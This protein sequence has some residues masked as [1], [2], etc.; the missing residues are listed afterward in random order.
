MLPRRSRNLAEFF[1]SR[2]QIS[3]T[4][5]SFSVDTANERERKVRIRN[6]S[7]TRGLIISRTIVRPS[8]EYST[9]SENYHPLSLY[10]DEAYDM[11]IV[12]EERTRRLFHLSYAGG[13]KRRHSRADGTLLQ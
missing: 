12:Q 7:V 13:N 11:T 9:C 5:F 3:Y 6:L 2:R 4:I 8:E 10:D 1:G